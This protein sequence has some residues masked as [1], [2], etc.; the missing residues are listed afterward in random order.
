M[1]TQTFVFA[2]IKVGDNIVVENKTGRYFH[3]V[4]EVRDNVLITRGINN[5]SN[6]IIPV[7]PDEI[8]GIAVAVFW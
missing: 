5:T 1:I 3:Q 2:D 7:Y 4:V 8:I 6:D